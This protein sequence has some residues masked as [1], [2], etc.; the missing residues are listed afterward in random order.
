C[1]H[2]GCRAKLGGK[3]KRHGG[4]AHCRACAG[5]AGAGQRRMKTPSFW[6]RKNTLST[7]LLPLGWAYDMAG[8]LNRSHPRPALPP[9][10]GVCVG[11]VTLGGSGKTPVALHIGQMLKDKNI[12]AYFLSRGYG[13]SLAGPVLVDTKK[14]SAAMVGDEPL[15]LAKVLPTVVA[16]DRLKGALY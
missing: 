1:R 4:P 15:L 2:A 9:G 3:Q 16:K 8:T 7:L 6:N 10:R 13:G 11:N 5:A 12:N 14:H